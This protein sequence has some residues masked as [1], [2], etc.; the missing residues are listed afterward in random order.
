MIE[1]SFAPLTATSIR[2]RAPLPVEPIV[3]IAL[4]SSLVEDIRLFA[5]TW[6]TGFAFFLAFLA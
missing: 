5:V 1:A 2:R 3:R 4:S 6:A